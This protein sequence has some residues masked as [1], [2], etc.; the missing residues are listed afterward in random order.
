MTINIQEKTKKQFAAALIVVAVSIALAVSMYIVSVKLHSNAAKLQESLVEAR[1]QD[2]STLKQAMRGY[3]QN[4]ALLEAALTENNET[5]LF[6]EDVQRLAQ[7]A[8]LRSEIRSIE[9]FDITETAERVRVVQGVATAERAYGELGLEM[10]VM[11]TWSGN[12]QFLSYLEN[13]PRHLV[14]ENMRMGSTFKEEGNAE[15]SAY[16]QLKITTK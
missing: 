11:G 3:E 14:I 16:Y 5:I 7:Q 9:L 6:I 12:V 15:W 8:G 1:G 4:A 13:I 10:T 2:M